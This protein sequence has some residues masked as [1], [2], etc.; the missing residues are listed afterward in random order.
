MFGFGK[1]HKTIRVNFIESG[2]SQPFASVDMPVGQLPET[3]EINT[4]LH[5]ADD[6]WQ[7]VG[8]TPPQK[9]EFQKS[10][11][12]DIT[13][14]KP[15]VTSIDPS[16]ILFSLPTIN[17]ELPAREDPASMEN[18][19][20]VHEDDWRQFEFISAQYHDE[21]TQELQSVMDIYDNQRVESG[22]KTLHIRK[23]IT[24]PLTGA[25][26]AL[27]ALEK[28]FPVEHK[29]KGVAFNNA[30]STIVNSFALQTQSG[31]I[32]WGQT[33]D[34]ANVST[35]CLRNTQQASVSAIAGQM[36]AFIADNHLYL[37]DWVRVFLCKQG[38][39]S[40]AQYQC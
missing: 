16:K 6:E 11:K 17:D 24:H 31:W 3:F 34:D 8:A 28:A 39:A 38:I 29:Y 5:I 30:A 27:S 1:K 12:L 20:V 13:L 35:L 26:I 7:V 22:F 25:Q 9:S 18:V 32:L 19:L 21:I 36:D 15:E 33:D 10:G 2:N 23:L 40:F 4:T 14:T 37:I